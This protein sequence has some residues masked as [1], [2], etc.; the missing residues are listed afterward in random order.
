[1]KKTKIIN[2]L[3]R[4]RN[5]SLALLMLVGFYSNIAGQV[6]TC[7][8][9]VQ[10]SVNSN[11]TAIVTPDMILEGTY[12]YSDYTVSINGGGNIINPSMIDRKSVV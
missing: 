5:A 10:V 3:K 7:N 9:N 8:D 4:W 1:M 2:T 12:N 11:C 6:V